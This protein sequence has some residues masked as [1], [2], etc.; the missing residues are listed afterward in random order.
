MRYNTQQKRMPLP[1]YG[2]SIQNMV[3]YALT[4]Q[5]RAERQRCANTIINIMG[6]M[7][8]HL[9]DV[10]DFKHKLWDH[11][12]IMS[13]FEL[14]I[15]YPYEIIRKD[16]LVTR[17]EQIPYPHARIRYRHYGRTLEVL[18]R[19]ATEFPEG[20][21]KQN[22]VALICNH[23][24]KDYMAWN[25]DTVDDRKIAEDL[26]ELSGGKLQLTEDIL[27]LMGER[28]SQSNRQK[29]NYNS[30]N[31]NQRKQRH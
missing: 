24:K 25:K 14:D 29:T 20:N 8:P 18:I 7:Y 9:R 6:S 16:N 1:E 21:E 19:K 30:R 5:D 12:A 31:S 17:P 2:R 3:D 26:Y 4:I 27:R 13:G 28:L 15:D 10:P 22:L 11:L 23:M